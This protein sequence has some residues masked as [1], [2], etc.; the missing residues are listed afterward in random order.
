MPTYIGEKK[1]LVVILS[2]GPI[3]LLGNITG[4]VLNPNWISMRVIVN[5]V[6]NGYLVDEINPDNYDDR[7]RL[8]VQ[9]VEADNFS[10]EDKIDNV[11]V[12][13]T[14]SENKAEE[15]TDN[16]NEE[17]NTSEGKNTKKNDFKKK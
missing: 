9:N 10:K 17:V 16:K 14:P 13:N 5:L 2:N 4:P 11:T 1:K 7:V 6:Q 12:E 3:A 8:T 15:S